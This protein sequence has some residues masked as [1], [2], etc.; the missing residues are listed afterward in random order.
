[1]RGLLIRTPKAGQPIQMT[2]EKT[3][4]RA[5]KL[6]RCEVIMTEKYAIVAIFVTVHS[7]HSTHSS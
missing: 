7:V 4:L 6:L 2:A 1:M 3:V 5:R